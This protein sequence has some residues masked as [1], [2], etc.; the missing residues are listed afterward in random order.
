MAARADNM[1]DM[2]RAIDTSGLVYHYTRAS[3]AL[4]FILHDMRLRL[5]PLRDTNDP[6]EEGHPSPVAGVAVDNPTL[7]SKLS[8]EIND[9][10]ER[11]MLA[12]FSRDR[13][14]KAYHRG[15]P[16]GHHGYA[17]DRM[18]AQYADSHRGVCLFFDRSTLESSFRGQVANRGIALADDVSYRDQVAP[19]VPRYEKETEPTAWLER[20]VEEVARDRS[21][22]KRLDWESE[23]EYRLL[24]IPDSVLERRPQ[25]TIDIRDALAAI[26]VGHRFPE[27]LRPCIH[28]VCDREKIN[29][30]QL[31]YNGAPRIRPLYPAERRYPSPFIQLSAPR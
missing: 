3:T 23:Q 29:A 8:F 20:K 4:E 27:G 13:P 1:A 5:S 26:C 10:M 2:L 9:R 17:R 7:L 31:K 15:L 12:C 24:F 11:R 30:F 6:G 28:E 19:A 21:F 22:V 14:G 16:L 25:E 18:W